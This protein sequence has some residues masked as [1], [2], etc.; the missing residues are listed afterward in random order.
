MVNLIATEADGKRDITT[1]ELGRP[2]QGGALKQYDLHLGKGSIYTHYG[3][4]DYAIA[5]TQPGISEVGIRF[6]TDEDATYTLSWDTENG[7]FSY[8]HLIDNITGIDTDCLTTSEYRFTAKTSDYKSR[9]KLVFGYTGVEENE[10][11]AST[12]SA[13][14]AFL[15]GNELVVNCGPST[16]S[17]T[18]TLQMFDLMGRMVMQRQVSG[19]QTSI[20][21]PDMPAGVYVLRLSGNNGTRTQKIVME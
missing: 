10:D 2:D 4:D 1:V 21:M 16:S 17:G 5:F 3:D 9:F 14:F 11:G 20:M 8:L 13:T 15:M 12:G 6:E 19:T 7:E 18:A